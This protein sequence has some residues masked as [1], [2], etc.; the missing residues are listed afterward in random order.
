MKPVILCVDDEAIVLRS[1]EVELSESF[2]EEYF[3][4]FAETGEEAIE[5]IDELLSE[6]TDIPIAIVDY[7]MPRL[8]GDRVLTIIHERS[9]YT[10][11]VLLTGQANLQGVTNAI[12][13]ADLYRY[14]SKPWEKKDLVLTIKEAIKMYFQNKLVVKQNSKLKEL[15]EHLEEK[16]RERTKALEAQKEEITAAFEQLKQTQSQLIQ[17]ERMASLWELTAG[18]SHELNNPLNFVLTGTEA[19]IEGLESLGNLLNQYGELDGGKIDNIEQF[20]ANIKRSKEEISYEETVNDLQTML[21]T[22]RVGA[23]RSSEIVKGL[24]AFSGLGKRDTTF[25][26]LNGNIDLTLLML[27]HRYQD[28]IEIKKDYN[29]LPLIE[30]YAGQINQLLLNILSNSIQSIEGKGKIYIKTSQFMADGKQF[31]QARIKDTGKGMSKE[32]EAKVFEPFFTTKDIGQGTGLGLSIAYGIV[33][34]HQGQ[35]ELHS[36]LG[37]GTEVIITFPTTISMSK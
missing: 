7:V 25:I 27:E 11:T 30:C 6:G 29:K 14:I 4:E 1:L 15:N 21:R 36:Q 23:K 10:K 31:V 28:V 9:P 2:G 18:L 32:V 3:L 22:I 17:S 19:L 33:E 13:H 37:K 5:I 12:N 35:I 26:E 24:R 20:I 16:V 8:K 34:M